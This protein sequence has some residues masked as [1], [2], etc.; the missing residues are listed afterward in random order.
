L[1]RNFVLATPTVIG[2]PTRSSTSRRSRRAISTGVPTLRS[3]PRASRNASSIDNPSTSGAVSSKT[4]NTALLASEYADIRGGTTTACGHNRR[5]YAS[6]I[7]VRTPKAFA[8]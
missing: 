8:S 7:A 4:R 1:A 3:I 5:A 2:K 6:P